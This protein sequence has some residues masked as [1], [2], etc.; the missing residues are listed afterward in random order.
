MK[1]ARP[2]THMLLGALSTGRKTTETTAVYCIYC[3]LAVKVARVEVCTVKIRPGTP[4]Q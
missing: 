1:Y 2:R 4:L 3:S